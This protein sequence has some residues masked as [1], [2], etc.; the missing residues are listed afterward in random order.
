VSDEISDE[1]KTLGQLLSE[2]TDSLRPDQLRALATKLRPDQKKSLRSLLSPDQR[3]VLDETEDAII[4]AQPLDADEVV[5]DEAEDDED[6]EEAFVPEW[7]LW[8]AKRVGDEGEAFDIWNYDAA[9][10]DVYSMRILG[11]ADEAGTA[12]KE[13]D[14]RWFW[15]VYW[16][17]SGGAR[18][19]MLEGQATS[20]AA[21]K[22]ACVDALLQRMLS[23]FKGTGDLLSGEL[24]DDLKVED[25]DDLDWGPAIEPSSVDEGDSWSYGIKHD[26]FYLGLELPLVEKVRPISLEIG[27][28]HWWILDEDETICDGTAP[29][30]TLARQKCVGALLNH[31]T[32]ICDIVEEL[33]DLDFPS[34]ECTDEDERP[35]DYEH[36]SERL[37]PNWIPEKPDHPATVEIL[38][39]VEAGASADSVLAAVHKF[40]AELSTDDLRE[41]IEIHRAKCVVPNCA[42]LAAMEAFVAV[43]AVRKSST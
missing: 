17:T 19:E 13:E 9:I 23:I 7:R 43:R 27:A 31:L 12:P 6:D 37:D 39:A 3:S 41:A 34:L 29:S 28:W 20:R 16:G 5:V 8:I 42:V 2:F 4:E 36:D 30:R 40:G 24:R 14:P 32:I 26:E 11:Y 33:R 25:H 35:S 1:K 10:G 18:N 38:R 21:A 15:E 22:S